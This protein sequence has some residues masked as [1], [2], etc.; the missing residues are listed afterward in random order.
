[1]CEFKHTNIYK[2]QLQD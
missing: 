1:M 2:G